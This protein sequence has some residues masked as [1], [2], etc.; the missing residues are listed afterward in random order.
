MWTAV[1]FTGGC[2]LFVVQD[3]E[4]VFCELRA[5]YAVKYPRYLFVVGIN[6]SDSA[7]PGGQVRF[8][9]VMDVRW[10]ADGSEREGLGKKGEFWDSVRTSGS[11]IWVKIGCAWLSLWERMSTRSE[12]RSSSGRH[13][14]EKRLTGVERC[15]VSVRV[16]MR[17]GR[18][19]GWRTSEPPVG[20]KKRDMPWSE[21]DKVPKASMTSVGWD[22]WCMGEGS[23]S[24]CSAVRSSARRGWGSGESFV[25]ASSS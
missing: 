11:W 5:Y 13:Y 7:V 3:G 17:G 6:E 12:K 24:S 14:Q 2:L 8:D 19:K 10:W 16:V 15:D 4:S 23:S 1:V 9:E 21:M 22:G 25:R 20:P 18:Y